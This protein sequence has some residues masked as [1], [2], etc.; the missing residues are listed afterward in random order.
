MMHSDEFFLADLL[1]PR[2]MGQSFSSKQYTRSKDILIKLLNG[3]EA[4]YDKINNLLNC[5]RAE[6]KNFR[7]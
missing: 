2:H 3:N 7:S 6:V 1:D 4:F 5:I